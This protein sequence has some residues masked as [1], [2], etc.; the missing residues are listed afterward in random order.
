M[1]IQSLATVT[2]RTAPIGLLA[3]NAGAAR[4][5]TQDGCSTIRIGLPHMDVVLSISAEPGSL[6]DDAGFE[7]AAPEIMASDPVIER[8]LSTLGHGEEDGIRGDAM[9]LALA[10]RWLRMR[11]RPAAEPQP[12]ADNGALQKWRLKRVKAFIEGHID[13]AISLAD[14]ARTAGLSRMYFA[15]RFRVATGLSPHEYVLRRRIERSQEML[16][17]TSESLVEIAFNVGFQTQAHFTTVFK[18]FVGVTPGRWR[19]SSRQYDRT[20]DTPLAV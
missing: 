16:A 17:Q 8:L 3:L 12:A 7:L 5:Q 18:R 13:Q 2:T 19:T 4:Q 6:A 14:L 11:S 20:L 9:R 10:A 15:A 1:S